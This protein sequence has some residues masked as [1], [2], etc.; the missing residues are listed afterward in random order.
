MKITECHLEKSRG[1]E[2]GRAA[3]NGMP[4]PTRSADSLPYMTATLLRAADVQHGEYGGH[5]HRNS[6]LKGADLHILPI[7]SAR[8]ERR[9]FLLSSTAEPW[10]TDDNAASRS[11]R[12]SR[13]RS[14]SS[15]RSRANNSKIDNQIRSDWS[16]KTAPGRRR[17][18]SGCGSAAA[19][20]AGFA[21]QPR[22][23]SRVPAS[24]SPGP[25]PHPGWQPSTQARPAPRFLMSSRYFRRNGLYR[26]GKRSHCELI[27]CHALPR[28]AVPR[29]RRPRQR[30]A[31]TFPE[32]RRNRRPSAATAPL[33]PRSL[34]ARHGAAVVW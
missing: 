23:R 10:I 14:G 34:P 32:P 16:S 20:F 3:D 8:S 28:P 7:Y 6:R 12:S 25:H 24:G 4:A 33:P 13:S 18:R 29:R 30:R 27:V 9:G 15:R 22:P 5:R 1:L 2:T 17:E 31:S 11:N 19:A 26:C 21:S